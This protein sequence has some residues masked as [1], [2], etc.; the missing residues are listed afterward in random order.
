MWNLRLTQV[1]NFT[2]TKLTV[3]Q[4]ELII[5]AILSGTMLI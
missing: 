5:P 4:D 2:S 1:P 3:V